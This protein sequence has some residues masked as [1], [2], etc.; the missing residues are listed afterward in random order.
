VHGRDYQARVVDVR[1]VGDGDACPNCGG[2]LKSY[3]GIEGGHI[4]VLGTHYSAKM[5]CNF[6]D[7]HGKEKPVVM[8]CYGIG[9]SRL[10]ATA[11]EQHHDAD[12][13]RWPLAIAPYHVVVVPAGKED[14]LMAAAKT[15][16]EGLRARGVEALLDDRDE[17]PGVKFK[18]AD[19]IGIPYRIVVGKKGL[20]EQKAELK[21]RTEKDAVLVPLTDVVGEVVNKIAAAGVKLG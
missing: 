20:A 15:I 18:D 10:V 7:E 17:R 11:I 3:R 14:E 4:F 8:G 5:S 21:A 1:Q 13:I 16:Y 19:L 6:L 12:G 2:A 9:V